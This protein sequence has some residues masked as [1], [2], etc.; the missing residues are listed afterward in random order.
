MV[1]LKTLIE[2][3]NLHNLEK[4]TPVNPIEVNDLSDNDISKILNQDN[5]KEQKKLNVDKSVA[6]GIRG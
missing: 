2:K 5:N 6:L 4:Y 1:D 3:L